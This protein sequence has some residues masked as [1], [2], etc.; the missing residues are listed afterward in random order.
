MDLMCIH[1]IRNRYI[2]SSDEFYKQELIMPSTYDELWN[3][4]RGP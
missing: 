2:D 1:D 4:L 3:I